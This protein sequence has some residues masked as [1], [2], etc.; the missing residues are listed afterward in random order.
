M[1]VGAFVNDKLKFNQDLERCKTAAKEYG[2]VPLALRVL[3][4]TANV[5][6][7]SGDVARE[8]RVAE[9]VVA[10]GGRNAASVLALVDSYTRLIAAAHEA[11]DAAKAAEDAAPESKAKENN[12]ARAARDAELLA[13]HLKHWQE[14]AWLA[15]AA[16]QDA[17]TVDFDEVIRKYK[18][19]VFQTSIYVGTSLANPY[20]S[21]LRP[22]DMTIAA[23]AFEMAQRVATL[24]GDSE[25]ACVAAAHRARC[26]YGRASQ[27][28]REE[29]VRA[30]EEL[31]RDKAPQCDDIRQLLADIAEQKT[32]FPGQ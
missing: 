14:L 20:V 23:R 25:Y 6:R 12:E 8:A 24:C 28:D 15:A 17:T 19:P 2:D 11:S 9:L 30:L 13:L 7:R 21:E 27:A 16:E 1:L 10:V 18:V 22:E 3:E 5:H 31:E 29:M 4:L 32:R 26:F